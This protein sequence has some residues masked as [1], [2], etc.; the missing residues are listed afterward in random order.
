[1]SCRVCR[2]EGCL[3]DK[4]TQGA[5]G[6]PLGDRR[7]PL[8]HSDDGRGGPEHCAVG[9][10]AKRSKSMEEKL[11][12]ALHG[13]LRAKQLLLG[14]HSSHRVD[15]DTLP[16]IEIEAIYALLS[17]RMLD[18]NDALWRRRVQHLIVSNAVS[19]YQKADGSH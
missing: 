10:P 14:S 15:M 6:V 12:H 4:T 16:V 3:G 9:D 1:M 19:A 17:D 8:G 11:R 2:A 5:Q 13:G 18:T 7:Q